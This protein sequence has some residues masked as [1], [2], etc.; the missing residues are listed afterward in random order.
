[1]VF[2]DEFIGTLPDP[3]NW[4]FEEGFRRNKELQWYQQ[5]N[6]FCI[7]GLLVIEGRRERIQNPN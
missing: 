6:A 2:E 5:N 3:N 4:T 7:D 1:L